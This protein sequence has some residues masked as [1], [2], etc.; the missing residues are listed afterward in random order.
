MIVVLI[1]ITAICGYRLW[2]MSERYIQEAWVKNSLA[3]YRPLDLAVFQNQFITDL[4]E[5]VNS[6]IIGWIKIPNTKIDYPFVISNNNNHYLRRDLFGNYA[7]AGSIFMDYRCQK[8]FSGF[9]TII[10]GHN[11]KNDSMFGDLLLFYDEGFFDSARY[12]KLFLKDRTYTLEFFAYMVIGKND[13][14]IYNPYVASAE[15]DDFIEH[16]RGFA[17]NYR[18][19]DTI[20]R[21]VTLSTC[22]DDGSVRVV[23]LANIAEN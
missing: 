2:V 11:M 22:S 15:G 9:N 21:V 16:V 12:G 10:Y 8:D 7:L 3:K 13:E 14:I 18:E 17:R 5:E 20:E 6:D 1:L 19:L 4:Q 23:L